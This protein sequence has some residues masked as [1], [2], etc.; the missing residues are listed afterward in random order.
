MSTDTSGKRITFILNGKPFSAHT[1]NG[2]S[3]MD[4]LRDQAGLIEVKNGC[5]PQGSCGCCAV[6]LE[7]KTVSSCVVPA[8]KVDGKTVLTL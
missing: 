7:D 6:I 3:L 2:M 4:L 8:E 5:A 1:D